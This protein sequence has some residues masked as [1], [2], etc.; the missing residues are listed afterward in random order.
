MDWG[1]PPPSSRI[2][3]DM[4]EGRRWSASVNVDVD[5]GGG[6]EMVM[7]TGGMSSLDA[8]D[9]FIWRST[10]ARNAFFRISVNMYSKWTGI[11]LRRGC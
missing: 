7:Y 6:G 5:G 10:V 8:P 2:R 11:Y 4:K 3:K 9:V 1:T